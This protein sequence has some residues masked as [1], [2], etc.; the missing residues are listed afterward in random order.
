[1]VSWW[2]DS[3]FQEILWEIAEAVLQIICPFWHQNNNV[4]TREG[5]I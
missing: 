4:R 3:V 5:K 2:S 1:M